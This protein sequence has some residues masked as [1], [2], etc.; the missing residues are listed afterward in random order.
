[1]NTNARTFGILLCAGMLCFMETI[2]AEAIPFGG[3]GS[4]D[5]PFL[6]ATTADL[7]ALANTTYEPFLAAH[8]RMTADIDATPSRIWNG[9][10]G[11]KPVGEYET[12]F[13]GVFDGD[14]HVIE[15]VYINRPGE[16]T[17]GVFA[18]ISAAAGIYR[19]GVTG[20]ITGGLEAGGI[21]GISEG[22]IANSFALCAVSGNI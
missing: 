14:G 19:L 9:G 1:M 2:A 20:H 15:N 8:Y 18:R 17:V 5:D 10:E 3:A 4:A 16:D 22:V 7:L 21:A 12:P 6:I 13:T 11:M